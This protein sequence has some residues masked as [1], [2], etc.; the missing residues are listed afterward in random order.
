MPLL[1]G[2]L[3]RRTE[4]SVRMLRYYEAEGLLT[5]ARSEAGYRRFEESDVHTV[6]QI[7][8]LGAAGMN[9]GV[10]KE[11]LPCAAQGRPRFAPCDALRAILRSHIKGV[12]QQ[13][14]LLDAS[15][16][17]LRELLAE[18]EAS[19]PRAPA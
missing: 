5:P 1:I 19:V 3:S 17:T 2:E 7:R 4:V 16:A 13:C 6:R 11:F 10:I 14:A 12:E 18:L 15:R 9:L 8:L